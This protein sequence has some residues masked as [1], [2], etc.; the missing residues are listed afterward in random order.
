MSTQISREEYE[1]LLKEVRELRKSVEELITTLKPILFLVEKIPEIIVDPG[2]FKSTAPI[3]ALPY[4]L[5]RANLN[6]LGA[7]MIGGIEC[8]SKSLETVASMEKPPQLSLLK[9]LTDKETKEAL[10]LL[11]EIL[12]KTVPCL[13]RSLRQYAT[14]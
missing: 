9:L 11:I 1:E 6:V 13:H 4:A 12:K 8:V 10:G 2:L 7:S 5:E 14:P 3:L